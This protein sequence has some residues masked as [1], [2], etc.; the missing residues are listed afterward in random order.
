LLTDAPT[1]WNFE[2]ARTTK[3]YKPFGTIQRLQTFSTMNKRGY[4]YFWTFSTSML[5]MSIVTMI[6]NIYHVFV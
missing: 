2:F 4:Y 1:N 3:V 5:C 6:Y